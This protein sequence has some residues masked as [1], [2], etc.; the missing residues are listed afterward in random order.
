MGTRVASVTPSRAA[1]VGVSRWQ[2]NGPGYVRVRHGVYV[3]ATTPLDE[4]DTRVAV[5]ASGLPPGFVV[6]GWAAARLH[7]RRRV[8]RA[9]GLL[10]FDG[11]LPEMDVRSRVELPV[12]VCTSRPGR[13]RP[14]RGVRLFRSDIA[15]GDVMT[16]D[17]V[18]VTSPL[19]TAFDLARLWTTTPAV[20][21]LDRLRSLGLVSAEPLGALVAARPGWVGTARARRALQLSDDRVESPRESMMRL[22]WMRARLPR[23]RCNA[24][25]R[26]LRGRFVGRVDLLDDGVGLVGEYDG[27]H[28]AGAEQR[29]SDAVRQESLEE[30]G[31]VVIRT[32]DRDLVTVEGR[33]AWQE[34]LRRAHRRARTW[35]RPRGWVVDERA[36]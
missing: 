26:D 29:W 24:V 23:P 13:L 17:G 25:V 18:P 6:G 10:V 8:G 30:L 7:E 21:A 4:L 31:L 5:I 34:R 9:D 20:V 2:L 28:H 1:M 32:L 15:A 35:D 11:R 22:L 14:Q 19:R 36:S 27:A 12:L 33:H 16:V 3:P